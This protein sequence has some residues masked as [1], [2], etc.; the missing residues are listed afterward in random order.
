MARS[1]ATASATRIASELKTL[2]TY[3]T[4]TPAGQLDPGYIASQTAYLAQQLARLQADGGNLGDSVVSFQAA[5]RKL[6]RA[7]GA[8]KSN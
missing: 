7:A 2:N 4:T 1:S 6:T 5:L 8:L 3:L